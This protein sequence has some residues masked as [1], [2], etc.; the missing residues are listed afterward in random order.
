MR[1]LFTPDDLDVMAAVRDAFNPD[2]RCSPE[3]MLPTA[4]ACGTEDHI[5]AL[6][7]RMLRRGMMPGECVLGSQYFK[8]KVQTCLA[9]A[10]WN[11]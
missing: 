8:V 10:R 11:C 1:K 4:G 5:P 3:K 7:H 6:R 2:G 9:S